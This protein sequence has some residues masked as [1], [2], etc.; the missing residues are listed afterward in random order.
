MGKPKAPAAP[1][2]T[3]AAQ[4][5]GVA[6]VN[7]AIA[8]NRLNQVNQVGPNGSLTYTYGTRE[9]GQ[10][11]T[12]PQTGQWIPQVTAT[13]TL[14]PEQQRLYDQTN[15][16]GTQLNDLAIRGIGYVDQ[17]SNTPIDQSKLPGQVSSLTIPTYQTGLAQ[18]P[19]QITSGVNPTQFQSSYD[20]SNVGA[21]PKAEDFAA[22][23][24]KITDAMMQRL[25]PYLD[26]NRDA[27][28]TRLANQGITNGSE[29]WKWDQDALNRS[30]NDQ[31]IAAL[32]AG[33]QEQQNLFNN[34]MG[35]RQQGVGEAVNQGNLFN[36]AQ[37]NTFNQ[38]LANADLA[39]SAQQQQFNQNLAAMNA[40]NQAQEAQ[41]QAGLASSQFQNQA[42]QQAIQEADYFKN[43][44]LNMLNALRSGNQV[45]MP[46]FG[47]VTAGAQVN[48]A[49]IYQAT[50]DQYQAALRNYQT[51]MAGYSG[52]MSGLGSLGGAAVTK[53]SDRRLKHGIRQIGKLA[54]GLA[55]YAYT[56]I[57]G[58]PEQTGVMA[59]EVAK[60][61]PEA[62]G[63]VIGGF[64]TVNYGAL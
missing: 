8:T 11:Y 47:N 3:A 64:Q 46:T 51:Q 13:T 58:G 55:V 15:Q 36:M 25:Q 23:R 2:Y 40:A 31:R 61:R 14:S 5:Q 29:A 59:D 34:A 24:D 30:E 4:Q 27:L 63:P 62:L 20:F 12:D 44:P 39:N 33:D 37:T 38:G 9:S 43:Q 1:D 60:L 16:M 7:S 6:N 10:G 17:A 49:P 56:Y 41:F 57:W 52:L 19:G 22:Q 32:L 26:K 35:I 48:S 45:Q 28:N 50:N 18:T 21:M 42:R 53:F 54:N